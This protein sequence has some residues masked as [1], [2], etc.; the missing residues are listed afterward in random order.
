MTEEK[1]NIREFWDYRSATFDKSPGHAIRSIE[2]EKAWK[3]LFT[4]KLLNCRDILDIGAGTGFLSLML[5]DMGFNVTGVDLSEKMLAQA[6]AKAKNRGFTIEFHVD[7]AENLH[8]PD[9]SFD[10]IVNRAVLWTLPHPDIAVK[11]W[12]RVLRPEGRLCFFLHGPH[13]SPSD[14]IRRNLV[15]IY[16]LFVERRNPWKNLDNTSAGVDL[17][18]KGGVNPDVIV[19]LLTAA[20]FEDVQVEQIREIDGLKQVHLP[21]MY[22]LGNRHGQFCYSGKKPGV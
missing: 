6:S 11:E 15:N 21:F 13:D 3:A 18:F 1:R 4:K 14:I 7:D 12:M 17:P 8:F 20:G 16:A 9:N 10:A 5:T 22:R 2:E 19:A